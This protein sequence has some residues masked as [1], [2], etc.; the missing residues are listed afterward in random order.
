[1]PTSCV[2]PKMSPLARCRRSSG[3]IGNAPAGPGCLDMTEYRDGSAESNVAFTGPLYRVGLVRL[4]GLSR[5]SGLDPVVA[6]TRSNQ[7]QPIQ[8]N[9]PAQPDQPVRLTSSVRLSRPK[10][11]CSPTTPSPN[12]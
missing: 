7:V 11:S 5:L 12:R 4:I 1:M 8:L 9:Q 2:Q 10:T 3:V 6:S